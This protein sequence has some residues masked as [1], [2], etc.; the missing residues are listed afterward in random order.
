M[1]CYALV[2]AVGLVACGKSK[3]SPSIERSAEAA[4]PAAQPRVAVAPPAPKAA[5]AGEHVVYS[6]VDNRLSAHLRRGGGLFL[7]GGSAGFAKYTRIANQIASG[8]K[9]PWELRQTEGDIKVARMTGKEATVY[10]PLTADQAKATVLRMK[11][12]AKDGGTVSVKVNDNKDLN[13]KA[14]KGWGA[15]EFTVPADQLHEGENA[16][17]IFGKGLELASLQIGGTA[18]DDAAFYDGGSRTLLIPQAGGMSWFVAIPPDTR[19]EADVTDKACSINVTATSEDGQVIAGKL[20]GA[21]ASV[22]LAPLANKA[23]RLDLDNATCPTARL[24]SAQLSQKGD[25]PAVKRGDAPKYVLF[26]VM[27]SLRADRIR[28][29]NPKARP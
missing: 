1:R 5:R 4:P 3:D 25:A 23:A 11:V 10:V 18:Q 6:L 19:L 15:L 8:G 24:A 9:R 12:F 22:D 28:A 7:D 21:G 17:A 14:D 27:D 13:A 16:L 20:A 29:I 26:V 2:V